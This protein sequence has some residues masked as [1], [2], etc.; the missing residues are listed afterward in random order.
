MKKLAIALALCVAFSTNA[1]AN[2][3]PKMTVGKHGDP[4]TPGGGHACTGGCVAVGAFQGFIL[5]LIVVDE[6][7]RFAAGPACATGRKTRR[8]YFGY[9]IDEPKL[10]REACKVKRSRKPPPVSVYG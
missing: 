9:V 4:F 3:Y 8:S 10:W 2:K 6:G 1:F 7:N 5:G